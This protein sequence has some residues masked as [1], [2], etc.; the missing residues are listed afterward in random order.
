M[1]FSPV[2]EKCLHNPW[3]IRNLSEEEQDYVFAFLH[4]FREVWHLWRASFGFENS[5]KWIERR[6]GESINGV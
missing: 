4:Q 1:Q 2:I 3:E 6:K 5:I